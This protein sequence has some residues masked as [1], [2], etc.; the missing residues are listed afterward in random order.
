MYVSRERS[1]DGDG[2]QEKGQ[3]RTTED[4]RRAKPRERDP[5]PE[6]VRGDGGPS[7]RSFVAARVVT[8]PRVFVL[9]TRERRPETENPRREKRPTL[10]WLRWAPPDPEAH[11]RN[12][13]NPQ[14]HARRV[15]AGCSCVAWTVNVW[16]E[17]ESK[18]CCL[19]ASPENELC[20]VLD[21]GSCSNVVRCCVVREA[22]P[23]W[24]P[25]LRGP[26]RETCWW[27]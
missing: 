18:G 14:S 15:C 13:K 23:L 20:V 16:D 1:N 4:R 8:Q 19:V 6:V 11:T 17:C 24:R 3:Q 26:C 21:T 7:S 2:M 5:S 9:P 22:L 12:N 27:Q 25:P 10:L